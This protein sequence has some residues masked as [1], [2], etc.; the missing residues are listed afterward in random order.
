M[1]VLFDYECGD[2]GARFEHLKM[3]REEPDP[4]CQACLVIARKMPPRVNIGTNRGRAVDIAQAEVEAQGF[5]NMKDNLREG[6]V[7]APS[8]PPGLQRAVNGFWGGTATPALAGKDMLSVAR[9]GAQQA[10]DEGSNPISLLQKRK[11]AVL[12]ASK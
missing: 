1:P 7:A 4:E 9:G 8:L 11:L 6:D 10:R 12:E 5:T 3:N 2:C